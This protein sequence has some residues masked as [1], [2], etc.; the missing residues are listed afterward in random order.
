MFCNIYLVLR[1]KMQESGKVFPIKPDYIKQECA[2]FFFFFFFLRTA[3]AEISLCMLYIL[4]F[5]FARCLFFADV[6]STGQQETSSY[7]A[8]VDN[9]TDTVCS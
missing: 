8:F 1:F 4:T 9:K 7:P 2:I 3:I 6:K 5:L